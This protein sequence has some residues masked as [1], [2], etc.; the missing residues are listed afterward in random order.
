MK[1]PAVPQTKNFI[2]FTFSNGESVISSKVETIK[3]LVEVFESIPLLDKKNA[4]FIVDNKVVFLEN[5]D[6][7]HWNLIEEEK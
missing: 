6:S 7:I 2:R 1:P 3:A 5:V 4:Y